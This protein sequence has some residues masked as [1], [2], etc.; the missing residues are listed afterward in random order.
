MRRVLGIGVLALGLAATA[1]AGPITVTDLD[2]AIDG[3]VFDAYCVDLDGPL[4]LFVETVVEAT[5]APMGGWS[6]PSGLLSPRTNAGAQAAW[7]YTE[8]V[9]EAS[10]STIARTALQVAL[11]NVLYD[12]DF[13]VAEN[14]NPGP[15]PIFSV[16][17]DD[18]QT[19]NDEAIIEQADEFLAALAANLAAANLAD[20]TWLQL[21]APCTGANC[22][23]IQDMI[24][25]GLTSTPVPE[26]AS[27]LLLMVGVAGG[28]AG[29]R[30][31][32]S[33]N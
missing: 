15:Q 28:F 10:P 25:P 31:E 21:E 23:D 9:D 27:A 5:A 33:R 16:R 12:V 3:I 14:A 18:F 20:A 4:P 24:G 8:F 17:V 30:R 22:P 7:L 11:W 1:E 26:P 13:T 2:P 32:R 29:R 19:V 6:D